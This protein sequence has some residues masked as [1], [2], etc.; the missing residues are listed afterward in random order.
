MNDNGHITDDDLE[1]LIIGTITDEAW[2]RRGR[3]SDAASQPP[4]QHRMTA[5]VSPTTC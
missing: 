1:R 5:W 4:Q 3:H 2:M